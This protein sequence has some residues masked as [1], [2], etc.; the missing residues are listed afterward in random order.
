MRRQHRL[1]ALR[2]FGDDVVGRIDR[3]REAEIATFAVASPRVG[4]NGSNSAVMLVAADASTI[5]L[6]VLTGGLAGGIVT[7]VISPILT[8]RQG[9]YETYRNW[10]RD[11]ANE[12]LTKAAEIR[13]KLMST[14]SSPAPDALVEELAVLAQRV[15]LIFVRHIRAPE[16][17]KAMVAAARLDPPNIEAFDEARDRFVSC[18]SDK[19][20]SRGFWQQTKG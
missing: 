18:A 14:P 4:P 15:E 16:A 11:L 7:G 20:R 10:Q 13:T 8:D 3:R 17:A 2:H 6:A 19:I 9:R 5:G 12:V 1:A